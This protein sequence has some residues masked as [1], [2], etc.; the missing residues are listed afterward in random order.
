MYSCSTWHSP[1]SFLDELI[2][3]GNK[4]L[5]CL[6][7]LLS[8]R[9]TSSAIYNA[10]GIDSRTEIFIYRYNYGTYRSSQSTALIERIKQM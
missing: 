2:N 6:K 9:H 4:S 5:L 1:Q 7:K 8:R 10:E 3:T